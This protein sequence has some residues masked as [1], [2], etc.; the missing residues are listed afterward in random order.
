VE[1]VGVTLA[2]RGLQLGGPLELGGIDLWG[3]GLEFG[4]WGFGIGCEVWI[5]GCR[6]QGAGCKMLG[7]ERR[8]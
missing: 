5:V 4:V 6:V 7:S 2:E 1:G 8:I 3:R